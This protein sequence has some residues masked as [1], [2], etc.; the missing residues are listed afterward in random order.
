LHT[1]TAPVAVAAGIALVLLA[2]GALHRVSVAVF[3]GTATLLFVTSAVFHRGR[4]GPRATAALQRLDHA[5]IFLVIAGTYTPYAVLLLPP[6]TARTLLAVVWTGAAV[7]VLFRVLWLR[8]PR[9]VYT[10][11]YIVLGWA[12]VVVLP[13]FLA[14]GR[15]DVLGTALLG[16]VLYTVGAI[17]YALRRPDPWPRWFG[18]HEVF[19]TLTVVAFLAHCVGVGLALRPVAA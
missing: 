19:H 7:G 10:P 1:G 2:D 5:S 4:W 16:G 13:D 3:A 17:V 6:G 14:G 11:A 18:F 9:W 8:A 12:A 15:P